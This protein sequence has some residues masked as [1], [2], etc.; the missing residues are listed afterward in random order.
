M[1]TLHSLEEQDFSG[2]TLEEALGC[3]LVWLM[4]PDRALDCSS[5]DCVDNVA[6]P[7]LHSAGT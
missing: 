4:A 1:V 5:P 2:K 3:W 6:A 7:H